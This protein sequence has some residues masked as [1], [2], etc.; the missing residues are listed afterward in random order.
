MYMDIMNEIKATKKVLSR[1]E[2]LIDDIEYIIKGIEEK[3][4]KTEVEKEVLKT[5][6][7]L[8]KNYQ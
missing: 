5:M 3:E 1:F 8:R 2:L 4:N 6:Y 7:H